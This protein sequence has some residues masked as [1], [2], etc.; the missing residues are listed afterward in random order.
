VAV[1]SDG[2]AELLLKETDEAIE[3][4]Q[5]RKVLLNRIRDKVTV[6]NNEI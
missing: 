4:P 1:Y 3:E 6:C 5:I 2:T